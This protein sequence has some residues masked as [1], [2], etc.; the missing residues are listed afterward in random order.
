MKNIQDIISKQNPTHTNWS[1]GPFSYQYVTADGKVDGDKT[2]QRKAVILNQH[3]VTLLS[4]KYGFSIKALLLEQINYNIYASWNGSGGAASQLAG[5]MEGGFNEAINSGL[6]TTWTGYS[7]RKFYNGGSQ[8]SVS[9]KIRLYDG[10]ASDLLQLPMFGQVNKGDWSS[11]SY[12]QGM[13]VVQQIALLSSLALPSIAASLKA[14]EIA[15]A[16]TDIGKKVLGE[17]V[18]EA[19]E[20]FASAAVK[21]AE[22]G[23]ATVKAGLESTGPNMKKAVSTADYAGS[24]IFSGV[25]D[26]FSKIRFDLADNPGTVK[27]FVGNWF[28]IQDGVVSSI[29]FAPSREMTLSGPLYCDVTLTIDTRENP[30]V[31]K[32]DTGGLNMGPVE[33]TVKVAG[34]DFFSSPPPEDP[35]P[36]GDE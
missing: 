13:S 26:E 30:S 7:T 20:G 21:T 29:S 17:T 24:R 31:V 36:V 25:A 32:A 10:T 11:Q 12:T 1:Q 6:G 8:I 33:Y 18:S 27:L 19:V 15:A 4:D 9:A 16:V 5:T 28:A 35:Q 34:S 22:K 2:A 23:Y 14:E 3:T